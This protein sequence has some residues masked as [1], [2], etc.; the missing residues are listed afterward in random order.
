MRGSAQQKV[1]GCMDRNKALLNRSVLYAVGNLGSKAL[2]YV[3]AMIYSYYMSPKEM[4]IYDV[5]LSTIGLLQPIVFFQINDAV[6]R[7]IVEKQGCN[8]KKYVCTGMWFL[9]FTSAVSMGLYFLATM[10]FPIPNRVWVLM[11]FISTIYYVYMQDVVRGMLQNKLYACIGVLNSLLMLSIE[12]V[13]LII[14]RKGIVALIAS[15]TVANIVCICIMVYKQSTL[16]RSGM[17]RLDFSI[18]KILL[19]Y[20][21]PL[22]PNAVSW[23]IVN[24]SDRYIILSSLGPVANGIYS[25]S[26]KFP[27]VL[28][29]ITSVFTLAWQ[30]T[31]IREYDTHNR[32]A[33]FSEVFQKYYRILFTLCICAIP[34]TRIVVELFVSTQYQ[35]AWRYTGCLFIA[36]T[37]S[38]LCSF[39]GLGYQ[40]SKETARSFRST[41]FSAVLNILTN[42]LLIKIV[43]LYAACISTLLSYFFLFC[44]RIVHTKRY[45]K[46]NINWCEFSVLAAISALTIIITELSCIR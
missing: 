8:H 25:M 5:I 30:E 7:Q 16:F 22:V 35:Q 21:T 36:A 44:I 17:K 34:A 31:A 40:I 1:V 33:F 41:V 42:I 27:T 28:A 37:F 15:K 13:G 4:G 2:A 43:G 10:W 12:V 24:S 32:D 9:Y 6:Y 14:L 11:L 29:M 38:A 23:W 3:M 46:L 19:R 39:L 26:N 45:F 20:S 18:L